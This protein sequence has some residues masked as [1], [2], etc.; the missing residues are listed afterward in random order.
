MSRVL[1][2]KGFEVIHT[3]TSQK[4]LEICESE[5]IA[6]VL[7]HQD[8]SSGGGVK[9][10]KS[11]R[12]CERQ[13]SHLF[14]I[15]PDPQAI[16]NDP[17]AVAAFDWHICDPIDYDDLMSKLTAAER[18]IRIQIEADTKARKV[19]QIQNTLELANKSLTI[20]S[21]RFEELFR[22]LPVASFTFDGDG[23]I[24]EWN[25]QAELLFGY[26]AFEVFDREIWQVMGEHSTWLWNLNTVSAVLDGS[27]VA[28]KEWCFI[29]N[30]GAERYFVCSIIP[31]TGGTGKVVGAI[32]AN[33]DI[34]DR[35]LAERQI[36]WQIK[37]IQ[38]QKEKLEDANRKLE[39][40]A[41]TDGLTG[42]VNHRKMYEILDGI[43]EDPNSVLSAVLMDVD[44]FK[45]FNDTYGHL[46]GDQVLRSVAKV[47]LETVGDRGVVARYGGEEF[48]VLLPNK[49]MEVAKSIA[50][51]VR[52]ALESF[53]WDL[54]Q[55]TV[56]VGVSTFSP[57]MTGAELLRR[58]DTALYMAKGTGKNRVVHFSDM[59]TEDL[60]SWAKA[61]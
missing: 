56:S 33:I 11:L 3:L 22:G 5:D 38:V 9:F 50:E 20:A 45:S 15:G 48:A 13:T 59:T 41:E 49:D 27:P 17:E 18:T 44:S 23:K 40:L 53:A 51:D 32:S 57:F 47:A 58:C 21:R 31:L 54:R 1:Q 55:V 4:A 16:Y 52:A 26:L 10:G 36:E 34:T 37:D 2:D 30:K 14:L 43:C 29:D 28:N 39:R 7:T 19:D 61:A 42:L 46:A 35:I 12:A 24:H 8:L 25:R 6:I 60:K